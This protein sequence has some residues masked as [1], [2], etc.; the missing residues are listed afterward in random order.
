MKLIFCRECE[1]VVRLIRWK[2][3]CR[4]KASG[5]QYLDDG[6]N[7][8]FWGPATPLGFDNP[9]LVYA[10]QRQCNHTSRVFEAFVIERHCKTFKKVEA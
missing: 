1:D 9:S 2:R 4:C 6:V 7:A 10:I 8:E 3:R 5:G